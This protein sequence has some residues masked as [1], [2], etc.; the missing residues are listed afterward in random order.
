M[1]FLSHTDG[2]EYFCK[3]T[4]PPRKCFYEQILKVT[5]YVIFDPEDGI[6][7]FFQLENE[8]Y[9]LKQPDKNGYHWLDS[10]D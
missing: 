6:L 9:Q 1:E 4:Y 10:M 8:P 3:R 2:G 7:E 5:V